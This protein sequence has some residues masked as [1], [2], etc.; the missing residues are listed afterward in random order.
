MLLM[1]TLMLLSAVVSSGVIALSVSVAPVVT[2]RVVLQSCGALEDMDQAQLPV[3]RS[4]VCL[5]RQTW[6]HSR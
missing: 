4:P 2:G 3:Q 6:Q 5:W 1:S